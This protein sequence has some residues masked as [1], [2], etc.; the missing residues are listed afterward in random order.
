MEEI[1]I[2]QSLYDRYIAPHKA[3]K[4]VG[5]KLSSQKNHDKLSAKV[6]DEHTILEH[7]EYDTTF[8]QKQ[9]MNSSVL[10][11]LA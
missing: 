6:A 4:K 5:E 1:N 11:L 2:I 7:S 9:K 3:S 10:N 8:S